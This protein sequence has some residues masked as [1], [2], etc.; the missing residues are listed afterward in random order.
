[1]IRRTETMNKLTSEYLYFCIAEQKDLLDF[2]K[3][4]QAKHQGDSDFRDV[5]KSCS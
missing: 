4:I 2:F 1:M 5:F 3:I